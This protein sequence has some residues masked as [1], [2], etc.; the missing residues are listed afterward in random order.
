MKI[1]SIFQPCCFWLA[2]ASAYAQTLSPPI[3]EYRGKA[4]GVLELR[5]DGDTP[6]AVILE[7]KGFSVNEDL[8]L[9]FGPIDPAIKV[10]LG[11]SSFVIS[12]H[13]THYVF[14][15]ASARS[16]P[17][18]FIINNTLTPAKSVDQGVRINFI[19]P[20]LVYVYQK[21]KLRRE[22]VLVRVFSTVEAG[23]YRLEFENTS[24]KLGRIRG[25]YAKGFSHEAEHG[26]FPLFPRETRQ[27]LVKAGEA[28]GHAHFQI[29][30]ED[31]F[32]LDEKPRSSPRTP[33]AVAALR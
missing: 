9:R 30:F 2:M 14:Y 24:S 10:E 6:L 26:G 3:A 19:L 25:I 18:W 7:L 29:Q 20:H 21:Q 13:Q 31:G 33:T 11:A 23:E 32:R 12:P 16:L 4:N 5:N 17:A 22:D 28:T 15:K 27:I 1:G 8:D